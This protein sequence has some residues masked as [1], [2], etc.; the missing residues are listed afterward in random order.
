MKT[1]FCSLFLI[2]FMNLTVANA[3][4]V[5]EEG[6]GVPIT[7][8]NGMYRVNDPDYYYYSGYRCYHQKR[9]MAGVNFLGLHA[10]VEGGRDVYCYPHP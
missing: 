7:V 2:F 5:I 10:G 8:E 4:V 3:A 9:D 6:V 1:I